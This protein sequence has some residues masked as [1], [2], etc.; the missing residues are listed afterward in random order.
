M[1]SPLDSAAPKIALQLIRQFGRSVK[2]LRTSRGSYNPAT[3]QGDDDQVVA[4]EAK[5]YWR[6]YEAHERT[7]DVD[8]RDI[9]VL[10]PALALPQGVTPQ[11]QDRMELDDLSAEVMRV[12]PVYSGERVALF[13]V[14]A[15]S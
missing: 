10:L 8:A 14:Q 6:R 13:R 7:G 15:R 12:S 1:P 9:L 3:G 5:A 2:L 4:Y 11:A